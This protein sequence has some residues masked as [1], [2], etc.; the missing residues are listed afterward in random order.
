MKS[1]IDLQEW[2]LFP[3]NVY[4]ATAIGEL[5]AEM[6]RQ[7]LKI[8][9]RAVLNK[10]VLEQALDTGHSPIARANRHP[11]ADAIVCYTSPSG[12][13]EGL[14]TWN[15]LTFEKASYVLYD[16]PWK[17]EAPGKVPAVIATATR[18]GTNWLK[19]ML[20]FLTRGNGY[21]EVSATWR[22]VAESIVDLDIQET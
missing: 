19:P 11:N 3:P 5:V 7:Y 14:Q 2:K 6:L 20:G 15:A 12:Y 4:G 1:K 13:E 21:S 8:R 22:N 18:C 17:S 10:R 9:V 16:R